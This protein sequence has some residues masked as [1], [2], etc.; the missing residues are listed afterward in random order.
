V[1]SDKSWPNDQ[2]PSVLEEG[3]GSVYN[4]DAG[5]AMQIEF[6][7][8]RNNESRIAIQL[9]AGGGH[10]LPN[11]DRNESLNYVFSLNYTG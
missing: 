9:S 4:C 3:W 7:S 1:Q 10:G 11:A 6:Q 2:R 5:T 8:G